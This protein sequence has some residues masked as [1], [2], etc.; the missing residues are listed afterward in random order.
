MTQFFHYST[1]RVHSIV[2]CRCHFSDC[3]LLANLKETVSR[4]LSQ[5]R[6]P[7]S[8]YP[9]SH[10]FLFLFALSSTLTSPFSLSSRLS[11]TILLRPAPFSHESAAVIRLIVQPRHVDAICSAHFLLTCQQAKGITVAGIHL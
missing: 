6:H 10:F 11:L 8:I 4:R 2:L 3:Y 5:I 1:D 7:L 9:S